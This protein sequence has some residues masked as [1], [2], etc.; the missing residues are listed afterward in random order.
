MA[1]A[2][3]VSLTAPYMRASIVLARC[4]AMVYTVMPLVM[5]TREDGSTTSDQDMEYSVITMAIS[6]RE[7]I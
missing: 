2:F 7:D 1:S 5:S 4:L 6:M 3:S